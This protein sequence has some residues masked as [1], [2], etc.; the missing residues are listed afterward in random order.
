MKINNILIS[1]ITYPGAALKVAWACNTW[2][3]QFNKQDVFIFSGD[4]MQDFYGHKIIDLHV[5]DDYKH[6]GTKQ[7]QSVKWIYQNVSKKYDYYFYGV[8]DSCIN[9]KNS[10]KWLQK[11]KDIKYLYAGSIISGTCLKYPKLTYIAGGPGI[12]LN[13]QTNQLMVNLVYQYNA[14]NIFKDDIE[15]ADVIFGLFMDKLNIKPVNMDNS[16]LAYD[17]LIYE[18][19]HSD[20]DKRSLINNAT[21]IHFHSYDYDRQHKYTIQDMRLFN[22][23]Y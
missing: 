11:F 10:I 6:T 9:A 7:I 14:Y 19:L 5:Q 18:S 21:L 1:F 4:K 16:Y 12:L 8:D 13:R 23:E 15:Y 22:Y 3:K 20:C 17:N 2:L